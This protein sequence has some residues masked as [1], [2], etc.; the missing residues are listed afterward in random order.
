M[1]TLAVVQHKRNGLNRLLPGIVDSEFNKRQQLGPIRLSRINKV[2]E[3]V[4][5]DTVIT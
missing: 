1:R 5:H 4:L 3:D 2:T